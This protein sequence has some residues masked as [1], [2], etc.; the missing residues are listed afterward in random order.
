MGFTGILYE[1]IIEWFDKV[2]TCYM[3]NRSK[4]RFIEMVRTKNCFIESA[5]FYRII[6]I[7][8]F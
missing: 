3:K 4:H 8:L 6:F 2:E 1:Y 7:I 5:I